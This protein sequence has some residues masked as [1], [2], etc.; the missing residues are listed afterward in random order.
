LGYADDKL[1][2]FSSA[3]HAPHTRLTML[4]PAPVGSF[5]RI[6]LFALLGV[7]FLETMFSALAASVR[8]SRG[9]MALVGLVLVGVCFLAMCGSFGRPL[10]SK[11]PGVKLETWAATLVLVIAS[12][13]VPAFVIERGERRSPPNT[14]AR[15]IVHSVA[16]TYATL[17]VFAIMVAAAAFTDGV[18]HR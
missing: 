14:L 16:S 2:L 9:Q 8:R 11:L 5:W 15:S 7:T 1:A 10:G 12:I 13:I 6:S 18:S 17:A 3:P 4:V